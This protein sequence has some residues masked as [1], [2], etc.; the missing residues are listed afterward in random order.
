[1]EISKSPWQS[2]KMLFA[3]GRANSQA[4]DSFGLVLKRGKTPGLSHLA[5]WGDVRTTGLGQAGEDTTGDVPARQ[6]FWPGTG[7]VPDGNLIPA[8]GKIREANPISLWRIIP[9]WVGIA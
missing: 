2:K 7:L 5:G 8:F 1:M 4:S 3:H 9:H 6:G